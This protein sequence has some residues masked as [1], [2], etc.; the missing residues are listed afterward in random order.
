MAPN[1]AAGP[2]PVAVMDLAARQT[3]DSLQADKVVPHSTTRA[4][5]WRRRTKVGVWVFLQDE[6]VAFRVPGKVSFEQ[7]VACF[8]RNGRLV[9]ERSNSRTA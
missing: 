9:F 8:E 6:N 3:D 2:W 7:A 1:Q 4:T 5:P